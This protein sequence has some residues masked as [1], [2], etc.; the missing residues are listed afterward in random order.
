VVLVT[1][2]NLREDTPQT[3][4][5][6]YEFAQNPHLQEDIGGNEL[7]ALSPSFWRVLKFFDI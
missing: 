7:F 1:S 5:N 6:V 3:T 2:E 4:Q